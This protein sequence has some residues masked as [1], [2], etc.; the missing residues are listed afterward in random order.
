MITFV[1]IIYLIIN[2]LAFFINMLSKDDV[3][4]LDSLDVALDICPIIT[5]IGLPGAL[6]GSLIKKYRFNRDWKKRVEESIAESDLMIK[7]KEEKKFEIKNREIYGFVYD[8][9][10]SHIN[11]K[12]LK[13]PVFVKKELP[14]EWMN[15]TAVK[16]E[17]YN[18]TI[19]DIKRNGIKSKTVKNY[20]DFGYELFVDRLESIEILKEDLKN[21]F[22]NLN[23]I[24][25]TEYDFVLSYEN[26]ICKHSTYKR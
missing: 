13:I 21:S 18:I 5:I 3:T 1:A 23:L 2:V 8:Y 6:L 16:I 11:N 7:K 10:S 20:S 19:V 22:N 9:L 25:S 15:Y 26:E 4:L 14:S 24:E 17:E 12:I